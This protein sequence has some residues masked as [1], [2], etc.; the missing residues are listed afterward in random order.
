LN[1]AKHYACSGHLNGGP[2]CCPNN[3]RLHRDK[4]EEGV[5]EGIRRVFLAPEVIEE[6]QRR[7]RAL[8]K[9]R[10]AKA[11]PDGRAARASTL[12]AE[13]ANLADA[14]AQ[15]ALR[16]SPAIAERLRAAE[17]ELARLEAQPVRLVAD[18]ERLIP[19]MA[20]EIRTGIESLP[21]TLAAGNVDLARQ[22]LKGYLGSIRVV[23][24]P[25]RMLLYS[26]RNLAEAV[27]ARVAGGNMASI[28]GSGGRIP[29]VLA[30]IPR[31][32]ARRHKRFRAPR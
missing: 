25:A 26:E 6:G 1:G 8:I 10:T 12:K 17:E 19:R 13:I 22:E 11:A 21:A 2:N 18:V 16:S 29:S 31:V 7:A 14:I 32:K 28:N 5:L 15:G 4:A 9:A 23:A 27:I 20:E 24:E 3:A 30:A